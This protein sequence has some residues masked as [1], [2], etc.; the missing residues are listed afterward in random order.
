[1]LAPI[2]IA[3]KFWFLSGSSP[4]R[5]LCCPL[6]DP[7]FKVCQSWEISKGKCWHAQCLNIFTV[8]LFL[9]FVKPE[10]PR[11]DSAFC[12]KYSLRFDASNVASLQWFFAVLSHKYFFAREESQG[13]VFFFFFPSYSNS[14]KCMIL[15]WC[16]LCYTAGFQLPMLCMSV[17]VLNSRVINLQC[18]RMG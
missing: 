1:M 5:C 18:C 16:T 13:G 17:I 4:C 9:T 12:W 11:F 2:C 10:V 14:D 3:I 8:N 7:C 15:T 6:P